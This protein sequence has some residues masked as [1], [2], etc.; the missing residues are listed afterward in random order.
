MALFER[1]L[2]RKC[3]SNTR[4]S[5][6]Y[7]DLLPSGDEAKIREKSAARQALTDGHTECAISI[8]T[9]VQFEISTDRDITQCD[10]ALCQGC[11]WGISTQCEINWG[12]ME[13]HGVDRPYRIYRGEMT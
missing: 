6:L 11:P 1:P 3:E 9:S 5:L 2:S 13:Q 8:G 4:V 12:C 10:L 7:T